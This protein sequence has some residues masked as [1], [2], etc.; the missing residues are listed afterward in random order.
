MKTLVLQLDRTEDAGSIRDKVTWGK[1]SRVLLVWPVNAS[2]L[3]RKIDLVVVKR[4]CA[5]QGSRLG[6][7]CDLP[8]ILAEAENLQIPV[9]ESVDRAM[10]KSWDRRNSRKFGKKIPEI[11]IENK[12]IEKLRIEKYNKSV[13]L[14]IRED[15][16]LPLF[17]LAIISLLVLIVLLFPSAS[18]KVFPQSLKSEMQIEFQVRETQ[19]IGSTPGVLAARKKIINLNGEVTI[20]TTGSMQVPDQKARGSISISNLTNTEVVIPKG[21]IIQTRS[22]PPIRYQIIEE[23]KIPVENTLTEIAIEALEPGIQGNTDMNTISN[24]DGTLGFQLQVTNPEPI[25][26]GTG[27]AYQAVSEVDIKKA[28]EDLHKQF[29]SQAE[30]KFNQ[31]LADDEIIIPSSIQPKEVLK[32]AALPE[33]GQ[34]GTFLRLSQSVDYSVLVINRT[35]LE[36]QSELILK[37]NQTANGWTNPKSRKVEV[38]ILSQ[39]LD[40]EGGSVILKTKASETLTPPL[41]LSFL[42]SKIAGKSKFH[43]SEIINSSIL[44]DKSPE[45]HT[46]PDWL[47]FMPFLPSR[48]QLEVD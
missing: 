7:V 34:A 30:A 41:D 13:F 47:P 38:Q 27:K 12:N 40:E 29:K 35:D 21:T 33:A 15:F 25:M 2:I 24:L 18:V 46:F 37:A 28:E 23:T 6:I 36:K 5:S 31:T 10:R 3:E 48:I 26:G 19:E 20:P 32:E 44:K 8:D 4:I 9:F 1:A 11:P 42:S 45:I 14:E 39:N 17:L 43:A 16:K 22:N